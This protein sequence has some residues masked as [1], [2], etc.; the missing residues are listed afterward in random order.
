MI[1]KDSEELS[2]KLSKKK[3]GPKKL[4]TKK[5]IQYEDD[6]PE[7]GS[8]EVDERIYL[9]KYKYAD[10]FYPACKHHGA[11]LCYKHNVWRCIEEGIAVRFDKKQY[12]KILDSLVELSCALQMDKQG[13][14]AERKYIYFSIDH[15][16]LKELYYGPLNHTNEAIEERR[17]IM[18][19]WDQK[20][21]RELDKEIAKIHEMEYKVENNILK[22]KYP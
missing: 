8:E 22:R 17:K 18:R 10:S 2:D 6:V 9:A 11:L 21:M 7:F 20:S 15:E 4:F 19:S 1:P 3:K 12:D 13:M 14:I 5:T 16:R